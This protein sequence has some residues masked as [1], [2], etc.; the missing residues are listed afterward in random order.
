MPFLDSDNLIRVKGRLQNLL[1]DIK[2]PILLSK[3]NPLSRLTILDAH[4]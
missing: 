1:Y 3:N 4:E 2:H